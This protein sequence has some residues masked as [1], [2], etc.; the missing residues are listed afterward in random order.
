M[1]F[2]TDRARD[3]FRLLTDD[4][5]I[6]LVELSKSQATAHNLHDV[7]SL[8]KWAYFFR[9]AE[10]LSV[11]E[12]RA[13]LPE[14]EFSEAVGV[15]EMISRTP[16]Q[17]LAYDA[18]LKF[19]RDRS[20][21]EFAIAQSK[22]EGIAQGKA[23]GIAQGEARG[24][25]IG[26]LQMLEEFLGLAPSSDDELSKLELSELKSRVEALQAQLRARK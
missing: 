8:E 19:E 24:V 3:D 6:H 22:E 12:L 18:R 26:Q 9:N 16:D 21:W 20:Q 7:S 1:L 23:E 17:R 2:A 5:Q 11:E 10:Q 13:A 15:L 25:L 4:L 14:P